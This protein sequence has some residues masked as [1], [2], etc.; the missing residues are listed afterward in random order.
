MRKVA[1]R[2]TG[3]KGEQK[4]HF[5]NGFLVSSLNYSG[6]IFFS[7]EWLLSFYVSNPE[8]VLVECLAFAT[9]WQLVIII[10]IHTSTRM[11]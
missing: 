10:Y 6:R 7:V 1:D 11:R 5:Q 4:F 2:D 9:V 3:N 8:H